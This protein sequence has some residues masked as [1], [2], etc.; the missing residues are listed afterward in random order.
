MAK[1]REMVLA[2]TWLVF[3]IRYIM[4]FFLWLQY[5]VCVSV[6]LFVVPQILEREC[7]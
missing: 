4:C 5:R 2:G 6:G 3:Y 1:K 7:C